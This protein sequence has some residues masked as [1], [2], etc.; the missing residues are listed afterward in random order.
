[1]K[2]LLFKK[3]NVFALFFLFFSLAL[4]SQY[5]MSGELFDLAKIKN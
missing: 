1:M 3:R 2:T 4:F 5:E